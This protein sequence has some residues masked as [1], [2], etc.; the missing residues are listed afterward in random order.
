[1][2]GLYSGIRNMWECNGFVMWECKGVVVV[3]CRNFEGLM[4]GI[5]GCVFFGV[6]NLKTG[7]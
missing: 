5:L 7:N 2:S 6:V 3:P 4:V 1:M